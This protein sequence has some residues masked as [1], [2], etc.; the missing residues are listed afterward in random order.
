MLVSI[1][2]IAGSLTLFLLFL[3][4]IIALWKYK[5]YPA[6]IRIFTIYL[7]ANL[8][9]EL[10]ARGFQLLHTN[11]L[12]L[13]HLFTLVEFVTLS[14]FFYNFIERPKWLVR[15][16]G[17][18]IALG[19]LLIVANSIFWE[20]LNA[21]NS[22]S[23]TGENFVLIVFCILSLFHLLESP[24]PSYRFTYNWIIYGILI[25]LSGSILIFLF[26][27][28]FMVSTDQTS[29]H[30]LIWVLNALLNLVFKGMILVAL[31]RTLPAPSWLPSFSLFPS[32]RPEN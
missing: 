24:N 15:Y 22:F 1:I 8:L 2:K 7:C 13:V 29:T 11:N 16:F 17:E 21:I 19:S 18:I 30:L 6:S 10:L 9:I 5:T 23:E 31:S 25:Y 20:P 3:S 4:V 28:Y 14:Y 32:S 26:S 27:R 12:W